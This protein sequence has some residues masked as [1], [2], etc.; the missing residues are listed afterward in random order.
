MTTEDDFFVCVNTIVVLCEWL[1]KCEGVKAKIMRT[2]LDTHC[3]CKNATMSLYCCLRTIHDKTCITNCQQQHMIWHMNHMYTVWLNHRVY[4]K[5]FGHVL[6]GFTLQPFGLSLII[7]QIISSNLDLG[8]LHIQFKVIG[9]RLVLVFLFCPQYEFS[10]VPWFN[11][12]PMVHLRQYF[13]GSAS[14]FLSF[15]YFIY[16][17]TFHSPLC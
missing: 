1:I 2:W 3:Y 5:L 17:F 11:L 15:L 14:G 9:N 8:P 6:S 10:S 4:P 16:L 13:W 12:C 7:F